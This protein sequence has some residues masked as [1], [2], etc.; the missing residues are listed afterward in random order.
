M[1]EMD[2][3]IYVHKAHTYVLAHSQ[4]SAYEPHYFINHVLMNCNTYLTVDNLYSC[5]ATMDNMYTIYS[6][7]ITGF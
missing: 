5:I 6:T 7:I 2:V 4:G 3:P 1:L